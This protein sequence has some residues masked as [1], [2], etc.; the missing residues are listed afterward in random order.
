MQMFRPFLYVVSLSAFV[1]AWALYQ[2]QRKTR[3]VPVGKA[4]AMLQ[5]AWADHHTRV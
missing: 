2:Q 4:A 3:H 1:T 5:K